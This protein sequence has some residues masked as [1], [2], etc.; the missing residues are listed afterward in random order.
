MLVK[1]EQVRL[2]GQMIC[3]VKLFFEVVIS[4]LD[5]VSMARLTYFR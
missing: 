5:I 3:K 4:D 1:V 2:L